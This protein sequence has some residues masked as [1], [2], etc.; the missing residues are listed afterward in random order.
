MRTAGGLMQR[1]VLSTRRLPKAERFDWWCEMVIGSSTPTAIASDH[2]DDFL[3]TA[4]QLPLG[5]VRLSSVSFPPMRVNRSRTLI[6][7][8]DPEL[9]HLVLP[10]RGGRWISWEGHDALVEK[11]SVLLH[12]SSH[13]YEAH[14][15]TRD[16]RLACIMLDIPCG[17]L[18]LPAAKI[19]ALLGRP[20]PA[21]SGTGLILTQ[22]L[23]Q[24]V[25]QA[26]VLEGGDGSRLGSA[27][28]DL[29]TALLAHCLDTTDAIA[30]GS[31]ER[32]L[33]AKICAFV[34]EHLGDRDLSPTSIASAHHV[35]VRSL[36]YLFRHEETTVS[37][38]IKHR[39]LE[40]CRQDLTEPHLLHRPIHSI[41]ERWGFAHP[42]SFSRAFGAAYRCTPREYR[43][44]ATRLTG[45]AL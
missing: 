5:D 10:R 35:S 33:L 29:V 40:R 20:L 21:R 44:H 27:A 2:R 37:A 17:R 28:C 34:E 14:S 45:R 4:A 30:P 24:V 7:K 12:D 26:D 25:A 42:Q 16:D 3:A 23:T 8:A 13:P 9:Y 6:R 1:T 18:P 41:A 31:R 15:V 22:F 36:H 39:R 19:D 32:V 43:E 38:W 11:G